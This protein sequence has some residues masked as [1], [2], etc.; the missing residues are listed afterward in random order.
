[1][2]TTRWAKADAG[3]WQAHPYGSHVRGVAERKARRTLQ[4]G[5]GSRGVPQWRLDTANPVLLG[6]LTFKG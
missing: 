6:R 5:P 2:A 3:E 1:M 4:T